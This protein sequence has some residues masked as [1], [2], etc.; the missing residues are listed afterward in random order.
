MADT[1]WLDDACS[2]VD[3]FRSGSISPLEALDASLAAIEASELNAVSH[4]DVDAARETAATADVSLP[5][6]GVP[7][8]VKELERVGGWPYTEASLVFEGRVAEDDQTSVTRLRATGAVLVAQTTAPEF[9]GVNCTSS[10]IHGTTR[11]PWNPERTPGGSSGGTAA[12]VAGG[13]LPIA[14]GSDGGGSIRIPAGFSGL[15]GLKATYGRI[16]KGPKTTIQP[17]T[18][19]FGVLT[20]SVRDTARY[21]DACNGFDTRDPYS[22]P[23]V[24][25]WE[26]GLGSLALA[27]RKAAIV[28]DLGTARVRTE[29]A[30]LVTDA[31]VA[32]ARDAGL[33]VVGFVPNLP[34]LGGDWGAASTVGLFV[35]LM[36]VYPDCADLLTFEMAFGLQHTYEGFD[37]RRAARIEQYRTELNEAMA[38]MFD[39]VDFLIC[40]CNPDVAFIAEGPPPLGIGGESLVEELGLTRAAMNNAALTAPSN[41]TGNPAVSIPVGLVDGLPVGMQIVARHH[42]EPLLLEL[43]LCAERTRPWPKVAPGAPC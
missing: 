33:D 1:P 12:S 5:F 18:T 39:E 22:L 31:G 24:E 30:D 7:F 34:P 38:D 25:G 19:T 41:M 15:F 40:S 2:L 36:D 35:D 37:L 27:G 16:P 43:S 20:R 21:F 13:L 42:A 17:L 11:N 6:G 4:L 10:R 29:V 9:G 14:T 28:P 3:A 26:A 8:G 23:R 32:L